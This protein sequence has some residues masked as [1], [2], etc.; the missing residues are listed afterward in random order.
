MKSIFTLLLALLLAPIFALP[1][2]AQDSYRIRSGDVLRVEVLED[3]TLNRTALV[4]PD[5]RVTLPL[6]G[7]IAASGRS[8]EAVQAEISA[9]LA[10]NFASAPNV[11]VG[12]EQIGEP[13][14]GGGMRV[15]VMGEA[16]A[17]GLYT[18]RSGSTL[19]QVLAETGGFT[20]FAATNRI[21]VQRGGQVM[22]FNYRAV[23]EGS[24]ARPM[25]IKSGD[26]IVIP[27]RRLFE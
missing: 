15:Y 27:T 12:I 13:V 20:R 25:V 24:A 8:I 26:V 6:A 3:T 16:A 22:T 7:S 1:A 17:P 4:A 9:K 5:G 2:S 18:V 19:L 11:Y 14:S 10:P 21:Q 23:E